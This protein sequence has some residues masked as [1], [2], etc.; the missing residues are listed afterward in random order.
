MWDNKLSRSSRRLS[1]ISSGVVGSPCR[2]V[3]VTHTIKVRLSCS[4][5]IPLDFWCFCI[6]VYQLLHELGF[7]SLFKKLLLLIFRAFHNLAPPPIFLHSFTFT[8]ILASFPLPLLTPWAPNP[9][10]P[11]YCGV[12]SILSLHLRN[13]PSTESSGLKTSHFQYKNITINNNNKI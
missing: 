11:V 4:L 10:S 2:H 12:S 1:N 3:E 8:L 5:I 9:L 6:P 13:S 7:H